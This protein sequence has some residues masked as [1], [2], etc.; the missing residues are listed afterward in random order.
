MVHRCGWSRGIAGASGLAAAV[1]GVLVAVGLPTPASAQLQDVFTVSDVAVDVTAEAAAAAREAA[2]AQGQRTAFRRL[3][4]RLTLAEDHAFLPYLGDDE[5]V[6]YVRAIEVEKEKASTVRYLAELT[7]RFK[8][9]AVRRLLRSEGIPYAETVS[10]TVVVLPVY[11]VAGTSMLWDEPNP[12]RQAWLELEREDVLVPLVTAAGDLADMAAIS[13]EQALRAEYDRLDAIAE[14]Y[15]AAD[16][17]VVVASLSAATAGGAPALD[18]ALSRFGP[19]VQERVVVRSFPAAA[20]E[21]V[22]DLLRRAAAKIAVQVEEDW[23][24]DNLLRFDW[25]ETLSV[26]VPL[27]GLADWLEVRRRLEGIPSIRDAELKSLSRSEA[28]VALRFIGDIDQMTL[29]VAQSDLDL[30]QGATSWILRLRDGSAQ[31]AAR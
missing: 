22:D 12:W 16:T 9:D 13:A 23:K 27:T 7:V 3:L 4:D 21:P 6:E 20:D 15:G 30:F 18:V 17:L 25:E 29:A 8:P 19:V 24:R 2:L 14:R 11:H 1:A 31:N 28:V 5:I 26:T 10:K